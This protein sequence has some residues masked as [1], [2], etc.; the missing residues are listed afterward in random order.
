MKS[1]NLLELCA[2]Q[3]IRFQSTCDSTSCMRVRSFVSDD[4][5]DMKSVHTKLLRTGECETWVSFKCFI[6]ISIQVLNQNIHIGIK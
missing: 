1:T 5:V 4:D 6:T 2:S 3:V